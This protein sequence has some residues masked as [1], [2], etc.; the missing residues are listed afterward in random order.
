MYKF[1]S[2]MLVSVAL[3]ACGSVYKSAN[4]TR[5]TED[6][7]T[8]VVSDVENY[9][10]GFIS[11]FP[12]VPIPSTHRINLAKSVIYKSQTVTMAKV[13]LTGG[14]DLDSLYRFFEENMAAN[15]WSMVNA[16]QSSQSFLHYAKPGR[17]VSIV[18]ENLGKYGN[19][20]HITVGPAE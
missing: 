3:T 19:A 5:V 12:D 8:E 1:L 10:K 17:F 2:L 15:D 7:R 16:I 11:A 6:G 13:T 18:I 20:V 14:G 9:E 4:V